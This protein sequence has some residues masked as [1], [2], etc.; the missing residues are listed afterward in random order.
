MVAISVMI[1]VIAGGIVVASHGARLTP[2]DD[3]EEL[4][5]PYDFGTEWTG[6]SFEQR[7][8][9]FSNVV[10]REKFQTYPQQG[11]VCVPSLHGSRS[12]EHLAILLHG[13]T[14]CPGQWYKLV[15]RLVGS[16]ITCGNPDP[17][18]GESP[19]PCGKGFLVMTPTLPGHGR[20]W[21]RQVG[22]NG[23][24]TYKDDIQDL[25][26]SERPYLDFARSVG[27]LAAQ[28][29]REHPRG[30]VVLVGHSVGGLLAAQIVITNASL[31]DRVLLM[32]PHIGP[33][34]RL[35]NIIRAMPHGVPLS[36]NLLGERCDERR[37]VD[38]GAYCQFKLGHFR[39]VLDMSNHLYCAN[40][41]ASRC[42][43][44]G[45]RQVD[46]QVEIS[47]KSMSRIKNLQIVLTVGDR[48]VQNFRARN[49]MEM[50]KKEQYRN[51]AKLGPPGALCHWPVELEH[52]YH[53]PRDYP[54]ID[55]WWLEYVLLA[56]ERF[57]TRGVQLE[58]VDRIGHASAP[59]TLRKDFCIPT[60]KEG[61]V[62]WGTGLTV[63]PVT[64]HPH[65]YLVANGQGIKSSAF[66][67][68]S[69]GSATLLKHGHN[70]FNGGR[71]VVIE[72]LG[73]ME[74]VLLTVRS[75]ANGAFDDIWY[76]DRRHAATFHHCLEL[77]VVPLSKTSPLLD[78]VRGARRQ[79]HEG[80][81]VGLSV[82]S[83]PVMNKFCGLYKC[84]NS[85]SVLRPEGY[86]LMD[87]SGR[88]HEVSS[89]FQGK[90]VTG[91]LHL[92]WLVE[93]LA[94]GD[95]TLIVSRYDEGH[96]PHRISLAANVLAVED[97]SCIRITVESLS[98]HRDLVGQLTHAERN[99]ESPNVHYKRVC[100]PQFLAVACAR[101]LGC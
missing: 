29:R 45:F 48:A 68:A 59:E 57:I 76:V 42:L 67:L 83:V 43:S 95:R 62:E 51:R 24:Y 4:S 47:K 17:R 53:V 46:H 66:V 93:L 63:L 69:D 39:A 10:P 37:G 99:L 30:Q 58:V 77:V 44:T 74:H 8:H 88:L 26:L 89:L 87:E 32:N 21:S 35:L 22:S 90:A 98:L 55:F 92:H 52:A 13:Y 86:T 79:F 80:R 101:L 14:G 85:L 94:V 36:W 84:A 70:L 61:I 96:P 25:P 19:T 72:L 11:D 5:S 15:E 91:R 97:A 65:E 73:I 100:S 7:W 78:Q 23:N 3:M 6:L 41:G 9:Q 18:T 2:G 16:E 34:N 64:Q 31:F 75:E 82:C 12:S 50:I 33:P 1:F 40:W 56:L 20:K 71:S 38:S 54:H 60:F 28:F 27:M 81:Q 49:L